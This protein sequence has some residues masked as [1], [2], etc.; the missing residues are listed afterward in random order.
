[1]GMAARRVV[2]LGATGT[3]GRRV[4]EQL[5]SRG[6]EVTGAARSTGV[7]A[8]AG[9]GLRA[10]LEGA[11]TVVDCLNRPALRRRPAVGFFTASARNVAAAAREAQV[12]HVVCLSIVNAGD[13][14]VSR[15]VGYYAGKAA[16]AA[17][18]T[19][20][21]LPVTVAATTQWFELTRQLLD[22]LRIGRVAG[23]PRMPVQPVAAVSAARF[24]CDV[25]EAGPLDRVQLAGPQAMDMAEACRRVAAALAPGTVVVP[26][27]QPLPILRH[28][29]LLPRGSVRRDDV[30]LEQWLQDEMARVGSAGAGQ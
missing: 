23:V 8:C 9:T 28:G 24:L 20:S 4:T 11:D 12:G 18:Y 6:H 19:A 14:A 3:M 16:Q 26:L 29:G 15:A 7:D 17:A 30:T 25:V 1:M 5:R 22:Q 2:V 21:G 27:P 13:P 10:A